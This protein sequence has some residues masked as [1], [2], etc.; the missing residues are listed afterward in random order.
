MGTYRAAKAIAS[1]LLLALVP[2]GPRIVGAA[3]VVVAAIWLTCTLLLAP[4]Y[5]AEL[6]ASPEAR[7]SASKH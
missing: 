7:G 3:I 5:R 6:V 1:L 4:R 2:I